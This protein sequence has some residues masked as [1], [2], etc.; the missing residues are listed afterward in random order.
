MH[1]YMFQPCF[2][3]LVELEIAMLMGGLGQDDDAAACLID[4]STCCTKVPFRTQTIDTTVLTGKSLVAK[5]IQKGLFREFQEPLEKNVSNPVSTAESRLPNAL[6]NTAMRTERD[7]LDYR[8]ALIGP[9]EWN[10]GQGHASC[11][12][13]SNVK[14]SGSDDTVP[15]SEEVMP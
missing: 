5:G 10:V 4:P 1:G 7:R 9:I 15:G 2:T 6:Y 11:R 13:I 14:V 8:R 3:G 12:V